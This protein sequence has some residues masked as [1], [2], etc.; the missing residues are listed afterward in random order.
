MADTGDTRTAT[1]DPAS[2][3][4]AGVARLLAALT[5]TGR[6]LRQAEADEYADRLLAERR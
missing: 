6:M 4:A 5:W 3:S 1:P 2:A